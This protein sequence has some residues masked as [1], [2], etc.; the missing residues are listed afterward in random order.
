MKTMKTTRPRRHLTGLLFTTA[1]LGLAPA[2]TAQEP[3]AKQSE[4]ETYPAPQALVDKWIETSGGKEAWEK[5]DC[6][7]QK[8]TI[9]MPAMGMSGALE[10]YMKSPDLMLST[11]DFSG[12]G[13]MEEGFDGT[14]AWSIDPMTGPT[15]KKGMQLVQ[16]QRQAS[17]TG[18]INPLQNFTSSRTTGK[19]EFG[20]A[21][22]WVVEATG[23]DGVTLLY[24]DVETGRSAGLVMTAETP[25][26]AIKVTVQTS[27]PKKFGPL[28]LN[29]RTVISVM[30]MEQVMAIDSVDFGEIDDSR[31]KLPPAIE[32][33][34]KAE[35]GD[36]GKPDAKEQGDE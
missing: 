36:S 11:V 26:G 2:A 8:G 27:E 24:F 15:L 34:V 32:T 3:A 16:A 14:T 18:Q 10:I 21:E 28:E 30:G 4:T 1:V 29:T 6:M 25:Q 7:T 19:A 31:F 33:M 12:L 22:C 20:G 23:E 9:K 13:K 17:F 5:I 35:Q